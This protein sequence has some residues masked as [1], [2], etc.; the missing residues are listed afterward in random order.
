MYRLPLSKSSGFQSEIKFIVVDRLRGVRKL[1]RR[2]LVHF[3]N[4]SNTCE[5]PRKQEKTVPEKSHHGNWLVTI[6][7]SPLL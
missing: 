2:L 4:I 3:S 7:R 1:P 6:G 5:G